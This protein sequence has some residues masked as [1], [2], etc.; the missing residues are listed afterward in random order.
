[1]L[2][3]IAITRTE[4]QHDRYGQSDSAE[5]YISKMYKKY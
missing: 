2:S 1:M 3:F 4:K 5:N